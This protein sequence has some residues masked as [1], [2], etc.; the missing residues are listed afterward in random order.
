MYATGQKACIKLIEDGHVH[1]FEELLKLM[2][3]YKTVREEM[4]HGLDTTMPK[5]FQQDPEI[6]SY[7]AD[8]LKE[9]EDA[10]RRGRCKD[11]RLVLT[12]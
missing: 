9:A 2:N 10:L 5:D 3:M 6:L 11:P 1:T 12:L 4:E 8:T 7:I